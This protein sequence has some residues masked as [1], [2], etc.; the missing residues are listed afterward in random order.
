M[1]RACILIRILP[2]KAKAALNAVKKIPEVKSAYF[3]FGR[4][5]IVAFAEAPNH[6]AISTLST[7][8]NAIKA[9]KSTE[10]LI[11]G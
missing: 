6:E 9:I 7:K 5:D 8:A 11:E 3:A 10:T 4:Y 1:V 2:G